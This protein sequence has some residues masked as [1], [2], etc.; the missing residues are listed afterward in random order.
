MPF[1]RYRIGDRVTAGEF[2]CPCGAQVSTLLRIEGRTIDLFELPGGR[3]Q[4]PYVL[5]LPLFASVPWLLKY[6][7]AQES[8]ERVVL[9][10]MPLPA[11]TPPPGAAADL[12]RRIATGPPLPWTVRCE[13]VA[14]I[15]HR[16]GGKLRSYVPLGALP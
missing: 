5:D 6:Q 9:R 7:F 10:L 3:R 12:E 15:G 4:H 14:D 1:I 8:V 11:V 2:G 16:P 13:I